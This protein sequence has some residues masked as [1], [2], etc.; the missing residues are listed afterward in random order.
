MENKIVRL[1]KDKEEKK[2]MEIVNFLLLDRKDK[3]CKKY[4]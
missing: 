3:L 2:V 4:K 1:E